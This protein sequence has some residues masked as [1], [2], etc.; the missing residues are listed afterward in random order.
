MSLGLLRAG[1]MGML[2][3]WIGF[4]LPSA[5]LMLGFAYGVEALGDVGDAAW[6]QGLKLVAVA[7]VAQAVWGMARS[8]APDGAR[9]TL[10]VAAALIALAVPSSLGQVGAIVLGAPHRLALLAGAGRAGDEAHAPL[11]VTLPRGVAVAAIVCSLCCCCCR[12]SLPRPAARRSAVRSVLPRRRA[13]VRRRPRRA[14]A[15]AGSRR[16]ARL[17]HQRR[18]PRRLR[19]GTGSAGPAV[20]L[21]RLSRRGHVRR[22]PTAALGGAARL[23][24]IFRRRSCW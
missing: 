16:A 2:A 23:V 10:A 3:A 15:A 18:L 17:G 14:A 13:G 24:A 19:R 5:L 6:L 12:C 21:R 7:V 11:G 22:R 9:A 20:H 8:L 4:T 1:P